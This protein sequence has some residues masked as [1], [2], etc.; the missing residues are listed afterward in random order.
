MTNQTNQKK[1]AKL[2]EK[3]SNDSL[4]GLREIE[5]LLDTLEKHDVTEFKLEREGEKVWLKRG[6]VQP[7]QLHTP[8]MMPNYGA[9]QVYAPYPVDNSN[10]SNSAPVN[11][12]V[13]GSNTPDTAAQAVN[14]LHA[15]KNV[16]EIRSPMVGTF[17]RRPAVDADPYVTE[18]DSVKKGDVLCI[19]EAMKLMN[20][21][22]SDLSGKILEV[23]LEDGQMVEYGEVLF[24]I[25]SV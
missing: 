3:E 16:K 23:C 2:M 1:Q 15:G 20:E 25:E 5:V 18:G 22:E 11:L 21:I 8:L 14:V 6:P 7:Q 17:Y 13:V 19:V 4:L 12:S 24:R 10:Q 9:P